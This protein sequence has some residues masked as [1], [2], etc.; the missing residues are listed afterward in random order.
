LS[1][2]LSQ[3]FWLS[4]AVIIGG[5]GAIWA[6]YAFGRSLSEKELARWFHEYWVI[7][8]DKNSNT[9]DRKQALQE[10]SDVYRSYLRERNDFWEKY[11]QVVV[12]IVIIVILAVLLLTKTISAEAG[13]PILSAVGGFAIAKTASVSTQ[14]RPGGGPQG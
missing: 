9:Y 13:L 11:G 5:G 1:F 8:F 7:W 2:L 6:V 12:A 14:N 4:I 10:F 3:E